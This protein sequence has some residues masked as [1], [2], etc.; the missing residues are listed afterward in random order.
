[1]IVHFTNV[2]TEAQ[3]GQNDLPRCHGGSWNLN[4]SVTDTTDTQEYFRR[5]GGLKVAS[6]GPIESCFCVRMGHLSLVECTR[7]NAQ[8]SL[9]SQGRLPVRALC[10]EC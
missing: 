1:M 2:E 4:P 10:T 3:R 5:A 8:L 9:G 7:G 6:Y